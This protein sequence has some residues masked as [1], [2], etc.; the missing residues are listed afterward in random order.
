[1][2]IFKD[3]KEVKI[4]AAAMKTKKRQFNKLMKNQH[5]KADY[6]KEIERLTKIQTKIK[7]NEN[8]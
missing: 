3:I 7:Q 2:N 1:M 6:I 4:N 5:M 8:L